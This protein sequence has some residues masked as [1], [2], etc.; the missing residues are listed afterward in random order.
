MKLSHYLVNVANDLQPTETE[1]K[2]GDLVVLKDSFSP[3]GKEPALYAVA[4]VIGE[5][6]GPAMTYGRPLTFQHHRDSAMVEL[7]FI[8]HSDHYM[9]SEHLTD[10]ICS[11]QMKVCFIRHA[12]P[13]EIDKLN[14]LHNK[15]IEK[16][17]NEGIMRIHGEVATSSFM[18]GLGR[19]DRITE[20]NF[21]VLRGNCEC[22]TPISG[23]KEQVLAVVDTA[24]PTDRVIVNNETF[25][26][27]LFRRQ[28]RKL[29][30]KLIKSFCKGDHSAVVEDIPSQV[31]FTGGNGDDYATLVLL[32]NDNTGERAE[33]LLGSFVTHKLHSYSVNPSKWST[34]VVVT[35]DVHGE[36]RG[37]LYVN[38]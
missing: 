32:Q 23:Q 31:E 2:V 14:D 13:D 18:A 12:T 17:I 5:P 20:A 16:R 15:A 26:E 24:K 4:N 1:F 28:S 30:K 11:R 8:Y 27:W 22:E 37:M 29:A 19:F 21:S 3:M 38:G 25:N 36:Y 33:S 35:M 10:G 9:D 7:V 34:M 6:Q